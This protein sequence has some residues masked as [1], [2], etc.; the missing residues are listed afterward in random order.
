M[1]EFFNVLKMAFASAIREA[2]RAYFAVFVGAY[3]GIHAE[4]S[5]LNAF[6]ER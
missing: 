5:R 6:R 1:N 4:F 3:R 2:P